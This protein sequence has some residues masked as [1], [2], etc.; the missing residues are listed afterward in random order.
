MGSI[1]PLLTY[2]TPDLA[3]IRVNGLEGRGGLGK[4]TSF[5]PAWQIVVAG[6]TNCNNFVGVNSQRASAPASLEELMAR[7]LNLK[8]LQSNCL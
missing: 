8:L 3:R 1:L 6:S 7:G 5:T 2:P 4:A